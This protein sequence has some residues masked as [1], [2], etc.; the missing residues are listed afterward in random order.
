MDLIPSPASNSSSPKK[1]RGRLQRSERLHSDNSATS[2]SSWETLVRD[3]FGHIAWPIRITSWE[4][5]NDT[6]EKVPTR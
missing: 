5:V 1:Q 6:P 3:S 4:L 2:Y